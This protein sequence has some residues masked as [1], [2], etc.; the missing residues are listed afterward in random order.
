VVE[1]VHQKEEVL[2]PP[3]NEYLHLKVPKTTLKL[4][5][6]EVSEM[7]EVFSDCIYVN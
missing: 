7:S 4:H 2:S 3:A 5:K 1:I 6:V